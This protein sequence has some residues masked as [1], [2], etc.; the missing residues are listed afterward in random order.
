MHLH[1]GVRKNEVRPALG[2]QGCDPDSTG[3]R[4]AASLTPPSTDPLSPGGERVRVRG[5]PDSAP[6]RPEFRKD[7]LKPTPAKAMSLKI[8]MLTTGY[9]RHQGDL[10]GFFVAD[11][12][13]ALTRRGHRV[14]VAAPGFKG[15]PGRE[16][17]GGVLLRRVSYAWPPGLMRLAY[18]GGLVPNLRARPFLAALL[19]QF[20]LCLGLASARQAARAD[21]FHGQWV[22]SGWLGLATR[23]VHG[24]PV[25]VTLR[26]QRPGPAAGA[27]RSPG[28][29]AAPG[30]RPDNHGQRRD[31]GGGRLPGPA[32]GAG[33]AD[34][35]TGWTRPSS[36]P[37]TGPPA[38]PGW[39]WTRIRP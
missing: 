6:T 9:P 17:E 11:L 24:A 31:P 21:L 15:G 30:I 26:G 2:C 32:R 16:E 33:P 14:E 36:R 34:P 39:G 28:P 18:G 19:P 35:P 27:A 10:F 29:E 12:A 23:F 8:S 7:P 5:D 37:G 3:N 1:R 13:R 38:G 25:A 4:R 20:L 22:V